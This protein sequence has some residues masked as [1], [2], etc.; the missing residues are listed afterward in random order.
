MLQF[1]AVDFVTKLS[2]LLGSCMMIISGFYQINSQASQIRFQ[3]VISPRWSTRV[4]A[5]ELVRRII[6]MCRQAGAEPAH[7]DLVLARS[8]VRG[9]AGGELRLFSV[10]ALPFQTST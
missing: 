10:V 6:S 1:S 3:N 4:F 9:G 2:F 8:I 7:F 5:V